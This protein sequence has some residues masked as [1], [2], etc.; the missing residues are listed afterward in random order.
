VRHW[1]LAGIHTWGPSFWSLG[2]YNTYPWG[3]SG[4]LV[5]R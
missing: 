2:T 1:P 4:A 3:P 5:G